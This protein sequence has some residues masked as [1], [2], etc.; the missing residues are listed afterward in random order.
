VELFHIGLQL[1]EHLLLVAA[2]T[3]RIMNDPALK[4][5]IVKR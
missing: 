4:K 2:E 3:K 1:I 5:Y